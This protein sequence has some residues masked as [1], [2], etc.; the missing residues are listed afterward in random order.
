MSDT[1]EKW[2]KKRFEEQA[3]WQAERRKLPWPE[4]L[5]ISVRMREDLKGFRRSSAR[6]DRPAVSSPSPEE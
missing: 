2:Q 4:K 5:R 3:A 1:L 6:P